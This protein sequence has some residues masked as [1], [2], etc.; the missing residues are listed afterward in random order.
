MYAEDISETVSTVHFGIRKKLYL[1]IKRLF[2]I[3]ISLL[4]LIFLLP[5]FLII[6]IAIK[7]DSK[8]PAIFIQDRIGL[9]G[10]LFKFYKFR[11]M[12]VDADKVLYEMLDKD[13]EI[14]REYMEN[15]KLKADPRITRIGNFIRKFSIDELPQLINV[16]KGDMS[17]IGN[18]PYLP[19]EKEDMGK[20]YKEIVISKPGLTG[21][22]QV[23]GRN[24]MTFKDRLKI[25]S[26]YS[27][28][29]SLK[30]DIKIFFKTF[31]AVF[32]KEGAQ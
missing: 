15:R 22:W 19:R 10:K 14:A 9:N 2:D 27:K 4:G 17:L 11:S 24:N 8:G 20:Y 3:V 16:L 26:N 7:I 29:M 31:K 18:R 25:E 21:L 28:N 5:I 30:L 12:V 32:G 13:T 6:M 1:G 23:S